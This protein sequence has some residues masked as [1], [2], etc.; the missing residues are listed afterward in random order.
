MTSPTARSL[1]YLRKQGYTCQ[2]VE[3]F[4]S[5]TKQRIDLFEVIDVVAVKSTEHGVLGVQATSRNNIIS[6]YQK[7][8]DEPRMG[9][10][11]DA[12]NRLQVHGWG[13]MGKKGKRKKYEVRVLEVMKD[14]KGEKE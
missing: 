4:N 13:I 6:R 8:L 14:G 9:V 7:C 1:D 3:K 5:F 12:G 11:L 10:W 2:V